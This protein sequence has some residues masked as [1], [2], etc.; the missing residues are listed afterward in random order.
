MMPAKEIP[1]L[2]HS[3]AQTMILAVVGAF[4][5]LVAALVV[6]FTAAD[7]VGHTGL[8]IL[9]FT[10]I[11]VATAPALLLGM[12]VARVDR[13]SAAIAATMMTMSA[14]FLDGIALTWF[15]ALYGT[16]PAVV[17]GGAASIMFGAGV[18]LDGGRFEAPDV[19]GE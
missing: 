14:L 12:R 16:D 18:A 8:T 2:P 10:L 7:W 11:F 1:A 19:G 6:R 15:T 4:Y 3:V 5:W 13:T 9:V 17:L